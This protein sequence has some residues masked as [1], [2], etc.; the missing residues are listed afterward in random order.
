MKRFSEE[1]EWV[2]FDGDVAIVGI[3]SHAVKELGDITFVEL[4]EI[5]VEF[6]QGDVLSVVES[7]KAASDVYCPVTGTIIHVNTLLEQE[8][9]IMSESPEDKGWICKLT[10]V[11]Q[12]DING[13]M[14]E[15]EYA[16]FIT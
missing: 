5:G 2:E 14:T 3:S 12:D 1:H 10:K 8:P 6:A 16:E 9:E 4:P 13:L 11:N 7:V 15:E